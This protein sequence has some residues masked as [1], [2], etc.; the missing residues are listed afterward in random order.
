MDVKIKPELQRF[1]EHEL[2]SGRYDSPVEI[3]NAALAALQTR[4]ELPEGVEV[5]RRRQRAV[6]AVR[7]M[8][9]ASVA[10]G[11][12]DRADDD[13]AEGIRAAQRGRA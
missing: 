12:A 10:D 8:Q 2:E 5:E 13:I 4:Q 9:N 1:I 11:H 7:E 3:I 6:E